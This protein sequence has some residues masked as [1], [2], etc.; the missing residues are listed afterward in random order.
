[1]I[2]RGWLLTLAIA[3]VAL[4]GIA[5]AVPPAIDPSMVA[6]GQ[7]LSGMHRGYAGRNSRSTK[8]VVAVRSEARTAR[9][10]AFAARTRDTGE[11]GRN[12]ARLRQLC[13]QAGY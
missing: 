10:C 6:Q 7:V 5:P 4:P 8:K 2:T 13:K 3:V 1:M 12:L 9:T 11:R